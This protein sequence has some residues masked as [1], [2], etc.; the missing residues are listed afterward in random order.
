MAGGRRREVCPDDENVLIDISF[1]ERVAG[2]F[3]LNLIVVGRA[4][5]VR[6]SHLYWMVDAGTV[7]Q[8]MYGQIDGPAIDAVIAAHLGG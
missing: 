8:A 7:L 3:T 2:F 6:F 5:P 4:T 1:Q